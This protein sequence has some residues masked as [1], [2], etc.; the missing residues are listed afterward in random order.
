MCL[1]WD[2]PLSQQQQ[3]IDV[4]QP[5]LILQVRTTWNADIS[6]CVFNYHI[7]SYQSRLL[8]ADN[9]DCASQSLSAIWVERTQQ[10]KFYS[11]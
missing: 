2:I 1:S 10:L 7:D 9:F 5:S 8:F 3:L 11:T 6:A 4:P